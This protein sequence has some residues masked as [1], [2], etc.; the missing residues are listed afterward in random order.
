MATI[1]S[2]PHHPQAAGDPTAL[3]PLEME[4]AQLLVATLRL[5][6]PAETIPPEETLF[7]DGL[8]LDSIDAL[9][10]A[11]AISR[12]YAVEIKSDDADNHRI[13]ANLRALAGHIER[14][15]AR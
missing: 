4:L 8:G 13:F 1:L 6:E 7:G 3:T 15:R 14:H 9:E 11:L 10:L 12:V 5:E 2:D